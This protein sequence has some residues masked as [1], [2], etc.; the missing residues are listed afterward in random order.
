MAIRMATTK[1]RVRCPACGSLRE[2]RAFGIDN[3]SG[4]PVEDDPLPEPAGALCH[5]NGGRGSPHAVQWEFIRLPRRLA[6]PLRARL[7][8]ALHKL[9]AYIS[10]D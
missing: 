7:A 6:I 2:P 3:E 10:E 9:D 1:E 8:A 4:E 5:Y